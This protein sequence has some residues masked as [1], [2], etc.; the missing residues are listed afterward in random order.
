MEK[1][2]NLRMH[3]KRKFVKYLFHTLTPVDFHLLKYICLLKTTLKEDTA[4]KIQGTFVW[5]FQ[6]A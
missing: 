3:L 5:I 6:I 2:P 4:V 1:I